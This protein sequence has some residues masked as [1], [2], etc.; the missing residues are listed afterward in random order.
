MARLN[1]EDDFFLEIGAVVAKIGDQDK[2]I[3]NAVRFLRH[4]QEKHKKGKLITEDEFK[5][6]GFL[7]ALIPTFAKRTPSGIQAVGANKHFGW[8]QQKKEA[9]AA[10]GKKS[11]T[12][13]R[14][15]KG[16]LLKSEAKSDENIQANSKHSQPSSS[17]SSS[18]S[19][20]NSPSFLNPA[21][22]TKNPVSFYCE[23]WKSKYNAR[24]VITGKEAGIISQLTKDLGEKRVCELIDGYFRHPSVF[25]ADRRHDL[26]TFRLRL[27]DVSHFIDTGAYVNRKQLQEV[28]EKQHF[29]AKFAMSPEDQ[30]ELSK[31]L[32]N[33]QIQIASGGK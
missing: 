27:G 31:I 33:D 20:S 18:S 8:L 9:G 24:P 28:E 30:T 6:K 2:A 13:K 29:E 17:S 10:G 15:K 12:R 16:R 7:D 14:D 26:G 19:I 32:K 11:A 23:L 22:S 5:D 3:G 25:F 1:I 4:A 21:D